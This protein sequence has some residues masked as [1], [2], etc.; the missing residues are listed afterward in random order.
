MRMSKSAKSVSRRNNG[1]D[2]KHTFGMERPSTN[3]MWS[4]YEK[5]ELPILI[6]KPFIILSHLILD[7][8]PLCWIIL[9]VKTAVKLDLDQS[10][11][12]SS[13]LI[14]DCETLYGFVSYDVGQHS[15]WKAYT[16][17]RRTIHAQICHAIFYYK[18]ALP[19]LTVK[20]FIS[21][22]HPTTG[23]V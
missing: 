1:Q 21:T 6:V 18:Y 12:L 10:S 20:P 19:I 14:L 8:G 3:F 22:K 9:T 13:D 16:W 2:L 4:F 23:P 15:R 5:S 7:F 17:N 11:S